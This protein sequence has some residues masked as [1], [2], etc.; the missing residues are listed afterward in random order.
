MFLLFK[1]IHVLIM[2][3]MV[4]RPK[5]AVLGFFSKVIPF[6]T[7]IQAIEKISLSKNMT[8]FD[9]FSS[10]FSKKLTLIKN[11]RNNSSK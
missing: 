4:N 8:C 1:H 7:T 6:P 11:N 3:T 5:L 2:F 9:L 10:I